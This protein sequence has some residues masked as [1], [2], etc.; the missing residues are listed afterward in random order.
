M[1][2]PN[3]NSPAI[4]V[5]DVVGGKYRVERVIGQGG[6]GTVGRARHMVLEQDV[7]IKVL[8]TERASDPQ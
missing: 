5:G 6:M 1:T 7:A 4:S 8:A 2:E 3:T